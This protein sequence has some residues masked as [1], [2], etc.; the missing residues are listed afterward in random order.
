MIEKV[1]YIVVVSMAACV[2]L[3][4]FGFSFVLFLNMFINIKR[5][6]SGE[7]SKLRPCVSCGHSISRSALLCPNCG[8]SY[9]KES[10]IYDSIIACFI[11]GVFTLGAGIGAF[12]EFL[13]DF[14]GR[15]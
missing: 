2:L 4:I 13:P 8:H 14:M 6:I 5:K 15:R 11:L 1:E 12:I 10:S 3:I 9:G 7:N